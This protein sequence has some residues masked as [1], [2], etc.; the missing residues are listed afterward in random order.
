MKNVRRVSAAA[1]L[2]LLL[3]PSAA[4]AHTLL[5][6]LLVRMLLTEIVLA[7]AGHQAHFQAVLGEG[8]PAAGFE[9][10]QF[11]IPLAINSVIASQLSTLPLGSSSGGFSY[12]FD[13]ALGTFSRTSSSFGSAFAERALTGGRG[14]WNAG[15][16]FQRATY[17]SLEGKDLN[18]GIKVYLTH[19]DCCEPQ[20]QTGAPPMPFF[21]GD[22]IEETLSLELT[23]STFSTFL[24]YGVTDR[25]DVGVVVPVVTI[26]MNASV[27]ATVIPLASENNPVHRFAGFTMSR[28]IDD[29]A[30]AQGLGDLV[31]RGKLRL[32][33]HDSGGIAAAVDLRLPTGDSTQLLGSGGFQTK[34]SF[35]GSMT[36]GAFAPHIN[37]GYT[38][39]SVDDPEPLSPA[40][41]IPNEI[42]YAAGFDH[43]VSPRLTVSSDIVGRSLRSLGRLVPVPRQFLFVTA[44]GQFGSS[45]F[46]EFTRQPGDLHQAAFAGG[47]RF[48][49]RGNLLISAHVLVPIT[50]T[51]LRDRITPVFGIDYSF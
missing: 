47:L 3:T 44:S 39:S 15:F 25:L 9:V 42:S 18:G 21:E 4:S 27:I 45:A 14:R 41:M 16:T 13:P 23:A 11:E 31:V 36:A 7:T 22:V 24:N 17:D 5:S 40:P 1:A 51:G 20:N 2:G 48:N 33:D 29:R 38:V 34:L 19:N 37:V 30:R 43:A 50:E 26:N 8:E 46:E 32:F 6:E 10:D 28:T 49:P 35:I 12:T